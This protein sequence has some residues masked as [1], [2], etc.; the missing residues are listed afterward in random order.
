MITRRRLIQ[1]AGVAPAVLV[2]QGRSIVDAFGLL[3]P[4]QP[5]LDPA[6][7]LPGESYG[8]FL[9]LPTG[10]ARPRGIREPKV[11]FIP[12]MEQLGDGGPTTAVFEALSLPAAARRAKST[13][14]RATGLGPGYTESAA[15]VISH[16]SGRVFSVTVGYDTFVATQGHRATALSIRFLL[17][18]P[19]PVPVQAQGSNEVGFAEVESYPASQLQRLAGQRRRRW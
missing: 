13:L 2:T 14:Y 17:D 16:E 12:W 9:I 4:A 5:H 18:P 10:A 1:L 15:A 8:G 11:R 3:P 7:A 19:R 6:L